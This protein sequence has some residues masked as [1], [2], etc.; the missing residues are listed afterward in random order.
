MN[1]ARF[2]RTRHVLF[3]RARRRLRDIGDGMTPWVVNV[4]CRK[5]GL[6]IGTCEAGV[7]LSVEAPAECPICYIVEINGKAPGE[8]ASRLVIWRETRRAKRTLRKLL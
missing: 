6:V 2:A 1:A 5:C 8:G 4:A 3:E 7:E